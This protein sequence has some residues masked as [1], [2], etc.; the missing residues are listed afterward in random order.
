MMRRR[1]GVGRGAM[2]CWIRK[3]VPVVVNEKENSPR[4]TEAERRIM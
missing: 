3:D 4:S 2:S 1:D